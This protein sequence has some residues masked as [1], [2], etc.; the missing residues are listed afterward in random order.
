MGVSIIFLSTKEV[1]V[2]A[3]CADRLVGNMAVNLYY[4]PSNTYDLKAYTLGCDEFKPQNN[5]VGRE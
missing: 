4:S 2:G 5:M 1:G 3:R